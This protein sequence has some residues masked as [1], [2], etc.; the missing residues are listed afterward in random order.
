M[1]ASQLL[2]LDGLLAQLILAVGV[3]MVLGNGFAIV[4]ERRGRRPK[5]APGEFRAARAWW[6][7]LVG[8]L[9]TLWAGASLLT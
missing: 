2:D 9:I 6:L 1:S 4:Q 5:A 7:L 8:T 3:A